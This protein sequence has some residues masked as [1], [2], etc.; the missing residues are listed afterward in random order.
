MVAL[1]G[2]AALPDAEDLVRQG[3]AAFARGDYEQ[4]AAFYRRAEE[5]ST[6]PGLVAFNKA[7]TLYKAGQFEDAEKHY[8]LCLGDAAAAVERS[9]RRQPDRD[10]PKKIRASAGPR[11]ARVL[12]NL[13]DCVV[14]RSQGT[15]GDALAWAV[16]LFDHCLRLSPRDAVLRADAGHNLQLARELVLLHPPRAAKR[17]SSS[18]ETSEDE[19]PKRPKEK[20]GP[21]QGTSGTEK[22]GPDK[23]EPDDSREKTQGAADNTQQ[24]GKRK[25]GKGNLASLPDTEELASMTAEQAGAFLRGAVQRIQTEER[26]DYEAQTPQS[27]SRK[28]LDW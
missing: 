3:N 26:R 25:A 23:K 11:L 1:L 6:D 18:E 19:P 8:W 27:S 17:D 4:A 15:D 13:G 20:S 22:T 7:A 10:L 28:V 5:S 14:Q 16:I 24:K 21:D 12:Y 9:L 2:A